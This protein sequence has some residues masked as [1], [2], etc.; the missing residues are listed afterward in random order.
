V[1]LEIGYELVRLKI[2]DDGVGFD[3][4]NLS[5]KNSGLGL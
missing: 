4:D 2:I 1:D 5:P 3:T